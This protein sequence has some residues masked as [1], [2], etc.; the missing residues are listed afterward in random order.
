MSFGKNLRRIR[1][2][3]GYSK[4]V[5]AINTGITVS[6]IEKY[7]SENRTPPLKRAKVIADFLETSLSDLM[8]LPEEKIN[9]I[10]A[11]KLDPESQGAIDRYRKMRDAGLT[12]EQ[13]NEVVDF[14]IAMKGIKK[15]PA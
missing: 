3:R 11:L 10:A 7:E 14:A 1:L 8:D 13:I 4:E 15:Q 12:E 9:N 2:A 6:N 5:L